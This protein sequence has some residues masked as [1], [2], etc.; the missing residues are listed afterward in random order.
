MASNTT[1][2]PTDG[3]SL[4][5]GPVSRAGL[6]PCATSCVVAQ[7]SRAA[8]PGDRVSAAPNGVRVS[9]GRALPRELTFTTFALVLREPH[10]TTRRVRI[11]FF[12]SIVV[13]RIDRR[14]TVLFATL[15]V[16]CVHSVD[17]T[18][19]VSS[20][21]RMVRA[22][23][24][25]DARC[26]FCSFGSIVVIASRVFPRV[27]LSSARCDARRYTAASDGKR[28]SLA[29]DRSTRRVTETKWHLSCDGP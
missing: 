14:T 2:S 16:K 6:Q 7:P 23:R 8:R 22:T 19:E 17:V 20:H 24:S 27:S 9:V 5:F 10:A 18:R 28:I 15:R 21:F 12:G 29:G 1:H 13:P 4:T 25:R 26:G 3:R 11:L